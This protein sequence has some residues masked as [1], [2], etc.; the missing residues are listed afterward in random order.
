MVICCLCVVVFKAF[1][2]EGTAIYAFFNSD[3]MKAIMNYSTWQLIVGII[4]TS[5]GWIAVTFLTK[6][7]PDEVLIS[8]CKKIRAGG[9]GWKRFEGKLGDISATA[10]DMPLCILCMVLGCL[11]VW[12]ALFGVGALVYAKA[13]PMF[14]NLSNT[15]SGIA[16][17]VISVISTTVLMKLVNKVKLS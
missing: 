7:E 14:G 10:W 6:P 12:T 11:A 3:G 1:G 15:T 2:G 16:L 17:L 8:F 13:A 4:V 5:I 9:P